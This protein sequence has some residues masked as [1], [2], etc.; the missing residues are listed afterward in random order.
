M[1]ADSGAPVHVCPGGQD[2][3]HAGAIPP[4]GISV[5]VVDVDVGTVVVDEVV[6]G[7][8]TQG[9]SSAPAVHA[10]PGGQLPRQAGKAPPQARSVVDVVVTTGA[11][12]HGSSTMPAVHSSPSGQLPS[13]A[14]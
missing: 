5:V 1:H 3:R 10:S 9:S 6:I 7:V 11:Q 2:P 12:A 13:Q 14:G 4:H 8:Q